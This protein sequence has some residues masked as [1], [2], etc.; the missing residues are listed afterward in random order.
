[1]GTFGPGP[2]QFSLPTAVAVGPDGSVYVA[3]A[4]NYRIQK[5]SA[6][7][8]Y[9]SQWGCMAQPTASSAIPMV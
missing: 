5:F 4:G 1:M 9:V 2:G 6:T 3:D 7:G 8:A